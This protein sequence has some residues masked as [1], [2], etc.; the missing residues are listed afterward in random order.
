MNNINN[1]DYFFKTGNFLSQVLE[2]MDLNKDADWNIMNIL[3]A[4][5]RF[6]K[7]SAVKILDFNEKQSIVYEWIDESLDEKLLSFPF[8]A[9]GEEIIDI[10]KTEDYVLFENGDIQQKE[11]YFK[12]YN[13][14]TALFIMLCYGGIEQVIIFE[15]FSADDKFESDEIE[16][17]R[18]AS[19]LLI[20]QFIQKLNQE[21]EKELKE[22]IDTFNKLGIK[23]NY[24]AFKKAIKTLN[25][26]D[27][28]VT[29]LQPDIDV[30][31]GVYNKT[32]GM[33]NLRQLLNNR[34]K[35]SVFSVC[36]IDVDDITNISDNYGQNECDRAIKTVSKIFL[37]TKREA[38]IF[39]R[40][41]KNEFMLIL[42]ACSEQ[43][44]QRIINIAR[45]L[46]D[47]ENTGDKYPYEISLNIG[48]LEVTD[49]V[50]M[51]ANEIIKF[52]YGAMIQ[53]KY[54]KD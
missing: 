12:E 48:V 54:R 50:K 11:T 45:N 7:L 51:D 43:N 37:E 42:Q 25:S 21:K 14:Q 2:E 23:I 9:L 3:M 24:P 16:I 36:F 22:M 46:L 1:D 15:K 30:L 41:G 26:L 28:D 31:T 10:L 27:I 29:S 33:R 49:D 35:S 44:A 5:G 34:E 4:C 18:Y 8:P 19:K 17:L 52:L 6:F 47:E 32:V 38:D 39:C 20:N 53:E 40:M 13:A